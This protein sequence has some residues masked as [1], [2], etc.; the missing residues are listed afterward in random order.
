MPSKPRVSLLNRESLSEGG[1]DRLCF[2]ISVAS[3]P[4][5]C[6]AGLCLSSSRISLTVFKRTKQFLTALHYC[7]QACHQALQTEGWSTSG[8]SLWHHKQA[9]FFVEQLWYLTLVIWLSR[10]GKLNYKK[11]CFHIAPFPPYTLIHTHS[12]PRLTV[13]ADI[14]HSDGFS[15]LAFFLA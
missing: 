10:F 15:A 2:H 12:R 13:L 11:S 6:R 14:R 9:R 5:A 8:G 1:I 7:W 3:S 4:V